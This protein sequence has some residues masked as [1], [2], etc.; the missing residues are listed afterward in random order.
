M[1]SAVGLL[2]Y[3]PTHHWSRGLCVGRRL[4]G[5]LSADLQG[6]LAGVGRKY[7]SFH[8]A[9]GR[10]NK[11]VRLGTAAR[12]SRFQRS[13]HLQS[14]LV[15]RNLRDTCVIHV[16][17]LRPDVH[18][19]RALRG[20]VAGDGCGARLRRGGLSDRAIHIVFGPRVLSPLG[21]GRFHRSFARTI[22]G[23]IPVALQSN[24]YRPP[25]LVP[26]S[27]DFSDTRGT[28]QQ[29]RCKLR[30]TIALVI[31]FKRIG[32]NTEWFERTDFHR[33]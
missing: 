7:R 19:L 17:H 31:V 30:P 3:R 18:H 14:I 6:F 32:E 21:R 1:G 24:G 28:S 16:L 2:R 13:D 5:I 26:S 9:F 23:G 29:V 12:A 20:V 27:L 15:D 33:Y 11:T 25:G 10:V 4:G 22:S 8:L